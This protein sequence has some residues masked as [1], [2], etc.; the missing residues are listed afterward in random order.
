MVILPHVNLEESRWRFQKLDDI[1]LKTPLPGVPQPT[2]ITLSIG[3][4]PF[5]SSNSLEKAIE[6]ADERMYSRKNEK[7][8]Q[9][10]MA[11][12]R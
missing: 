11:A 4:S 5:S 9:N 7:K 12:A 10:Q 3:V 8:E 2:N 1:L 6:E